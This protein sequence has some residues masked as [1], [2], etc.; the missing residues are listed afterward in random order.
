MIDTPQI[1]LSFRARRNDSFEQFVIGPNQ[2]ALTALKAFG[3]ALSDYTIGDSGWQHMLYLKGDTGTGKSFLLNA[4][5]NQARQ[6]GRMVIYLPL[7]YL[8]E[9]DSIPPTDLQGV[10]LL[11]IDGIDSLGSRLDWQEAVFHY[12]NQM[13]A[14]GG[15]IVAA[16]RQ[17]PAN[18]NI[19]LPD[20]RSRLAWGETHSLLPLSDPEKILVLQHHAQQGGAVINKEV[21]NYLLKQSK[22]DLKSLLHRLDLL[23][24]KSFAVKRAASIPL[25]KEVLKNSA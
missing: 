11:C 6:A 19:Q 8:L 20:L 12:Y 9:N 2:L 22:R 5:G 21:L 4:L 7:T 3:Q 23:Q 25:L 13:R 14:S 10:D 1:P 24:E 18:V 17:G 16:G 15:Y